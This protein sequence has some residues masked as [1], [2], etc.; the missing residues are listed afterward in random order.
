[1]KRKTKREMLLY[2]VI[3]EH[4]KHLDELEQMKKTKKVE[5][6]I[7]KQKAII[8]H[9]LDAYITCFKLSIENVR[10]ECKLKSIRLKGI[11]AESEEK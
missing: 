5:T 9:L 8:D 1:M 10:K 4:K 11:I 6:A 2:L 7:D 3:C